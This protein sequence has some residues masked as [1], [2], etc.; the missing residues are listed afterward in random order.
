MNGGKKETYNFLMAGY[1]FM[2]NHCC[3]LMNDFL[4]D[5]RVQIFYSP[6]TREYYIPL[7]KHMA[8]QCIFY[9]PWCGS[10][11]P[12]DLREEYFDIIYDELHLEPEFKVTDTPG[13]PEEFKTDEW[14][15]KRGL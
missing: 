6:Q 5:G 4:N 14:W 15:K 12:K 10:R 3:S 7:K 1:F 11:L 2:G 8:V 9:C 13:L